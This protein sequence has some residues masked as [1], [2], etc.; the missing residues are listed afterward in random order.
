MHKGIST[1]EIINLYTEKHFTLR[2][3]GKLTGLSHVG[4]SKRLKRA[5]IESIQGTWVKINCFVCDD[6][7]LI[8]RKEWKKNT[9]HYCS[10]D[11]YYLSLCNPNYISWRHGQRLARAIVKQYFPLQQDHVVHHDDGNVRNNRVDN[12]I[13]FT[14][15]SD[16]MKH[17]HGLNHVTPLWNGKEINR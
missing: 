8:H 11:C 7:K 2:D 1:E 3:I 10:A 5:G 15:Q 17:H 9:R 14:N 12:L 13:V 16:H 4:V 6:E